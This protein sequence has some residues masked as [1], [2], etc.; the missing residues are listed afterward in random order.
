MILMY[1]SILDVE[2]KPKMLLASI[3]LPETSTHECQMDNGGCS[4]V[5]FA[6]ESGAKCGCPLGMRL[7]SNNRTCITPSHCS[8]KEFRCKKDDICIPKKLR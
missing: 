7:K 1:P 8:R 2:K 4:H 5:C 6:L 3:D